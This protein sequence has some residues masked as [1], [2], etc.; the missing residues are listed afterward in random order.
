[1]L[2]CHRLC[3]SIDWT[4]QSRRRL[5]V[6]LGFLILLAC[7]LSSEGES[8][9]DCTTQ[10]ERLYTPNEPVIKAQI[11]TL[12]KFEMDMRGTV[13]DLESL[14]YQDATNRIVGKL[15]GYRE[16]INQSNQAL[17]AAA[18][19]ATAGGPS[20]I[21]NL[22]LYA[23]SCR[24]IEGVAS[25]IND[26][27]DCINTANCLGVASQTVKGKKNGRTQER[28]AMVLKKGRDGVERAT[29]GDTAGTV[30]SLCDLAAEGRGDKLGNM[31]KRAL[32]ACAGGSAIA[33]AIETYE[34]VEELDSASR[35]NQ[36]RLS[37]QI[38]LLN[39]KIN[40][41]S[42]KI[43]R[44]SK[45]ISTLDFGAMGKIEPNMTTATQGGCQTHESLSKPRIT[46]VTPTAT[47]SVNSVSEASYDPTAEEK[48]HAISQLSRPK[49]MGPVRAT[50][51]T[52]FEPEDRSTTDYSDTA[53]ALIEGAV[54]ALSAIQANRNSQHASPSSS[55][56]S[57]PSFVPSRQNQS[58]GSYKP[59]QYCNERPGGC[60][61]GPG[62]TR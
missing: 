6:F 3:I 62:A 25:G 1:M 2:T 56:S 40:D 54:Q 12:R 53:A 32:E 20:T 50:S 48:H 44:L 60:V 5:G 47:P 57:G 18:N 15:L 27:I 59:T 8:P 61:N 24:F 4:Q 52:N 55:N 45:E 10:T 42:E 14:S 30:G 34:T 7:P 17:C 43:D 19:L 29:E 38:A 39:K 46:Q 49:L 41:T 28:V 9:G 36:A 11:E 37:K 21:T 35:E 13:R 22:K 33:K 26:V 58:S 23:A 31:G 16:V 51:H